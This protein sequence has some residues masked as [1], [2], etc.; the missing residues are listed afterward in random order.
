[1]LKTMATWPLVWKQQSLFLAEDYYH[2]KC[3]PSIAQFDV[4]KEKK[5]RVPR[6][7]MTFPVLENPV[8]Q[9]NEAG[10][11]KLLFPR[12]TIRFPPKCVSVVNCASGMSWYAWG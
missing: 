6:I 12:E 9:P 10:V 1:M 7:H 4:F 11:W 8:P 5:K 2:T 3:I